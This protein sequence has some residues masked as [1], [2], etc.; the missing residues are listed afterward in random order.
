MK[1]ITTHNDDYR[2]ELFIKLLAEHERG[3]TRYVMSLIPTIA[4]AEDILQESK[5]VMWRQFCDFEE[6][7]NFSAWGRK[8]IFYRMLY[9]KR[10]KAKEASQ[11]VFSDVF[12]EVLN[13]EYETGH[14]SREK[15]FAVL[16]KCITHLQKPHKEMFML[17]YNQGNSI[18]DL[19]EKIGRT[20][21]ACYKTLSRI[22]FNLKRC[23]HKAGA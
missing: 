21:A 6:G 16:Q 10:T 3:L 5:L 18:E 19:A 23:M 20:V 12:Y 8:I 15:N 7:T 4:D 9:F 2:S 17:R 11:Y 22:R 14:E 13:E 1:D